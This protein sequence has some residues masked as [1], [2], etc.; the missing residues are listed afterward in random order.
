[1]KV[2]GFTWTVADHDLLS[3]HDT[4]GETLVELG[5]AD[6]R[7]VAVT[8]DLAETTKLQRFKRAFP[9]RCFNVGVAEQNLLAVAAGLAATGFVPVVCTYAT[10]V[11]LRAAEFVR[12]TVA[13]N[14]RNVKIIGTLAGVAYG[15]GGPTH[16]G[17]EDLALMRAIPGLVVLTPSDGAEMA[18]ALRAA[19]AHEGP[20][21]VRYGRGTEPPVR[22]GA[23][24]VI[25]RATE[26]REGHDATVL[27]CG[28]TVHEALRAAERAAAEGIQTRVLAVSTLK[29]FDEATV[30]AAARQ[31][32]RLV[33]VED[34]SVIGGLGSAVAETIARAG[35]ACALRTLGHQ[36]RF[37]PMGVPEDLMHLGG[38]DEDAIFA[39]L[40]ELRHVPVRPDDDWSDR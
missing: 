23:P 7:L 34:H 30:V 22:P 16:H 37:L 12:T 36:D 26:L 27:A 14:G 29:P 21:Y 10:F 31:T 13:Y 39:A 8:A 33:T 1:M 25:G 35:V 2:Q 11:A 19:V 18:A 15:Q 40:C 9:E 6:P 28:P 20:V 38:F 17:V 5:Q 24:F 3:T 4:W 32:R